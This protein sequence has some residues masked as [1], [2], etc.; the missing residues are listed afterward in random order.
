MATIDKDFLKLGVRVVKCTECERVEVVRCKDCDLQQSCK[1]AQY[2]G[3]EGYCSNAM[4]TV[5]KIIKSIQDAPTV[6]AV[7]VVRGEWLVAYEG[8]ERNLNTWQHEVK[9]KYF[10]NRCDY[11]TGNQ[12]KYFNFCPNCGADMRK[13][14]E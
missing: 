5:N 8:I 1:N 10:C 9:Y 7:P 3:L 6:A 11:S 13:K 14:V 2:L 4:K 12:G